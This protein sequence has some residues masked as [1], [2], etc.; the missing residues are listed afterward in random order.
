MKN[1]ALI[2]FIFYVGLCCLFL[3]LYIRL[4][5]IEHDLERAIDTTTIVLATM[6]AQPE[7]SPV[8][9]MLGTD[10]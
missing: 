9:Q 5:R 4:I 10:R 3:G 7:A 1:G 2:A 8:Y 6:E